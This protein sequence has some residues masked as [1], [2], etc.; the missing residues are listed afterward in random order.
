MKDSFDQAGLGDIKLKDSLQ[1]NAPLFKMPPEVFASPSTA[2]TQSY[3][4]RIA[5]RRYSRYSG[6]QKFRSM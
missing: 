6:F 5:T 1:K 3:L 2:V 4:A